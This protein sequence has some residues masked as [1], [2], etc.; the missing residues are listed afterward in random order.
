MGLSNLSLKAKIYGVVIYSL[1][2]LLIIGYISISEFTNVDD[3]W[4]KFNNTIIAKQSHVMRFRSE[5]G[6]GGAIHNFKNYVLRGQEKHYG[7]YQKKA[8][9]VKE[10]ISN[11]RAIGDVSRVEA[12][13]LGSVEEMIDTYA[14]AMD[15]ARS[16]H[17]SGASINEI[18]KAIKINDGPFLDALAN[19]D[20]ELKDRTIER[21][22]KIGSDMSQ[23]IRFLGFIIPVSLVALIVMGLF[24][25]RSITT[26]L[27]NVIHFSR[28]IAEGNLDN[29]IS[30]G[31]KDEIGQLLGSFNEMNANLTSIVYDVKQT[32]NAI[33]DGSQEI[34]NGNLDLSQRTEEQASSLE[35][36]AS[37]I[38]E[39]TSTVKQNAESAQRA[40]RVANEARDQAEN[41]GRVV[42]RAVEAMSEI[43]SAS[44]EIADIISTIDSI[45][46]QTNLL[47]LNAA[48][49]AARAG[50]QGRGFAVVASE[51]RTLAQRSAEAAKEI[52][53]LIGNS[54]QKVKAGTELVD[55]S[56]KVLGNIVE[57]VKEV[58]ELVNEID[59][60]SREQSSGIDQINRAVAQMDDMTQQNAALVEQ[61]AAASRSMQEKADAMNDAMTFFTIKEQQGLRRQTAVSASSQL[62]SRTH[63]SRLRNT[64][65]PGAQ[66]T[67]GVKA[68]KNGLR[69]T[70]K[71]DD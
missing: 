8:K 71:G 11:Y 13:A 62:P 31:G 37:S 42:G 4:T 26:P 63:E 39:M 10:S 30:I 70:S 19:F 56:G 46:F 52:K 28:R 1:A 2:V 32:S 23:N 53:I 33:A 64:S 67:S 7:N 44:A 48:V 6:Y 17:A 68:S 15:T 55:E 21:S 22:D 27:A 49:E 61:S 41:G 20:A 57:R 18:D 60:A 35:E 50:D 40:N 14:R 58:A 24:L 69:A 5:M 47:A 66:G 54:V 16:M 43:N 25:V 45:A 65:Q 34:S 29:D 12:D 36:T 51:V 38:E 3:E 59:A 9:A